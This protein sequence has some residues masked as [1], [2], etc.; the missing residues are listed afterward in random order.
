MHHT[1]PD[2]APRCNRCRHRHLETLPCWAGRYV[3]IIRTVV[4]DTYGTDCWLCGHPDATTVD[5][6]HPR[7]RGGTDALANLRPAHLFCNTGRGA[8]PPRPPAVTVETS[9]RW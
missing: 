5:H 7:S 8:S 3:Q 2:L 1:P 4:F 6:V 9:E